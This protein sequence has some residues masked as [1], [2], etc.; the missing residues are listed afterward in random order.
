MTRKEIHN[1]IKGILKKGNRDTTINIFET[2]NDIQIEMKGE[3][4][5]PILSDKQVKRIIDNAV[6]ILT[7]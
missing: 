7:K 4:K 1:K 5:I 3:E 2:I 6:K